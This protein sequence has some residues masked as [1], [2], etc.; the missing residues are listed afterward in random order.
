M[1]LRKRLL[2]NRIL[3]VL[4]AF[5]LVFSMTGCENILDG[6][7][8]VVFTTGFSD[9]EVFRIE[10]SVCS[11]QE[12]MVY[13]INT[14]NGYESTFGAQIW[15]TQ[16]DEGTVANQLKESILAKVAQIKAMNLLAGNMS[17]VLDDSELK[18][19]RDAAEAYY[20]TLTEQDI[21]AMYG[22]TED[23]IFQIYSEYA[24]AD[25][26]YDYI[27]RDI[28]PEIS[29]DEA[30][31]ITVEQIFLKTYDLDASG[32]KVA[33]NDTAKNTVYLKARSIQNQLIDGTSFEEL[34]SEYNEAEESTISFGKGEVEE[35]YETVAFNLGTEEISDVVEVSDGYVIIKCVT[36]F[37]REETEYNKVR[38]VAER[39]REVFGEQYDAYVDTLTKELNEE[40]WDSIEVTSD[41][42]VTTNSLWNV[43]TEYFEK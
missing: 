2:D 9:D 26:L 29:D 10:D 34:M 38:I 11:I 6:N 12:I 5:F 41:E 25:K 42:N 27:I 24:L 43:Y 19:A 39:K 14:Q 13:L 28:N 20:E 21:E 16:T 31:T 23:N 7:K 17:I 22:V 8:K 1:N 32:E 36:T 18:T 3:A 4:M 33:Y 15:D 37:N 35:A 40:L 30:R